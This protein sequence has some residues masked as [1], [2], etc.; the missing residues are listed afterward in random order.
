MFHKMGLCCKY[1]C[2]LMCVYF[3]AVLG[4]CCCSW[5]FSGCGKQRRLCGYGAQASHCRGFSWG[6]QALGVR[7]QELQLTGSRV[8]TQ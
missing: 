2:F 5:S 8:Q 4:L 3:L 7:L 6:P 1:Y